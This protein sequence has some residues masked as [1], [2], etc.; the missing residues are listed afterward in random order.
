MK[1]ISDSD[2]DSDLDS[3]TDFG[4]QF[5]SYMIGQPKIQAFI[6]EGR[7]T[8]SQAATW[9]WFYAQLR[10]PVFMPDK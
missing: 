7:M 2:F 10:K 5:I 3:D 6:E 9:L 8:R 1:F 4:D